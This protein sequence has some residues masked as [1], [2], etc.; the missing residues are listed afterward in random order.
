MLTL[1]ICMFKRQQQYRYRYFAERS[2]D[3]VFDTDMSVP[4]YRD[5]TVSLQLKR[6]TNPKD[7]YALIVQQLEISD[8]TTENVAD[9]LFDLISRFE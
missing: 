9:S 3:D 8:I 5:C 6:G 4:M 1:F 7:A 2:Q